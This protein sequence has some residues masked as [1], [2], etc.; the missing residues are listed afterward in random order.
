[1]ARII[2]RKTAIAAISTAIL[3]SATPASAGGSWWDKWTSSHTHYSGCGHSSSS[4]SSTSTS[5]TSTSTSGGSTTTS[6]GST[7]SGGGSTSGGTSTSGGST[8]TSGGSTTSGGTQVP[9]PGM[10]GLFGLA[11]GAIVL[12]R[13]RAMK[14]KED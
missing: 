10:L 13:R 9:E 11:A 12:R 8:T 14:R 2:N 1:M 7:T 3:L 4:S 6:G 5:T